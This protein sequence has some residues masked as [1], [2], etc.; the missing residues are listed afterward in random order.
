MERIDIRSVSSQCLMS[1]N[2]I[3]SIV[4]RTVKSHINKNFV[5]L[6]EFIEEGFYLLVYMVR[7]DGTM[8]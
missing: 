8:E 6:I 2:V 4:L 5:Y 3:S 1:G 7:I